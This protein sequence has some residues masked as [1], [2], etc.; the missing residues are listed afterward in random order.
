MS[1][2]DNYQ[3]TWRCHYALNLMLL[4]FTNEF[5]NVN[6]LASNKL[7]GNVKMIL[8]WLSVN[9]EK[10]ITVASLAK[11][12][13]YHPTYLTALLKKHTGHTVSYYITLHRINAAK[14]LLT[15]PVTKYSTKSIAYMCGFK[16]EKYFLRLFKKMEG[17]T[18]KEYRNA[19]NEKKLNLK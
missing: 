6:D 7:P 13:N 3:A 11:H 17:M 1:K 4:E 14:N 18:P 5:L 9:Y 8:E 19:F 15:T 16:D 2:R 12:F 10:P